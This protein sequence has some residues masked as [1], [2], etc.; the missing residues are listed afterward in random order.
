MR[1]A[2]IHAIIDGTTGEPL[3]YDYIEDWYNIDIDNSY[4]AM[5]VIL[6]G[7]EL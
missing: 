2:F 1:N 5:G 3:R 6:M 4:D 7:G